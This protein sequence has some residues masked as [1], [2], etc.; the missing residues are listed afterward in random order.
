MPKNLIQYRY[1]CT[2]AIFNFLKDG[3]IEKLIA[4]LKRIETHA[5]ENVVGKSVSEDA[6]LWFKFSDDDTL[7][8]DIGNIETDLQLPVSHSN[9]KLLIEKFEGVI[10]DHEIQVFYS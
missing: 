7:A 4:D 6:S 9:R 5:S 3:D 10:N 1:S 8:T 2:N